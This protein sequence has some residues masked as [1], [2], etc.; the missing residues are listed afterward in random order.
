[1]DMLHSHACSPSRHAK[2]KV[3]HFQECAS[4]LR[5]RR[6]Q[7]AQIWWLCSRLPRQPSEFQM[8]ASAWTLVP[9][10]TSNFGSP[11]PSEV[12][13]SLMSLFKPERL[14][15]IVVRSA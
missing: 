11:V 9:S 14:D 3:C 10:T 13:A 1:M 15:T 7:V 8:H 6:S 12:S 4:F 2:S 5:P